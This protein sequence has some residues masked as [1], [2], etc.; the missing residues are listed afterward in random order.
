VALTLRGATSAVFHHNKIYSNSSGS[1]LD[2]DR[3]KAAFTY[4]AIVSNT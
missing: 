2:G 3:V 4:N 1:T